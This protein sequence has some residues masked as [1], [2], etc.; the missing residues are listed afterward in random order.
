MGVADWFEG[1][2]ATT[3]SLMRARMVAH[4]A[5]AKLL[6]RTLEKTVAEAHLH[7]QPSTASNDVKSSVALHVHGTPGPLSQQGGRRKLHCSNPSCLL[8]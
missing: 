4:D 8:V 1:I 6:E 2:G 5:D 3:F 7:H